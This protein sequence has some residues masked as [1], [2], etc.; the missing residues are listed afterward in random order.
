MDKFGTVSADGADPVPDELRSL[1]NKP[2]NVRVQMLPNELPDWGSLAV[3]FGAGAR[4]VPHLHRNGQ[5]L[6]VT[7]GVGVVADEQGVHVVRAGDVI[8]NPPGT[9]HWHGATPST[10]MTHVT[11]ETPGDFDLDVERRD[12]EETYSPDL[13]K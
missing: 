9:W 10:A 8:S 4:T 6:I 13:G 12:W 7:D 3:H 5:H 1:F 11:V 2:D